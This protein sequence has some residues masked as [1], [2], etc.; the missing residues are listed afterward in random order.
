[1]SAILEWNHAVTSVLYLPV[2]SSVIHPNCYMV[3]SLNLRKHGDF[4]T[5]DGDELCFKQCS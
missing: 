2:E 5:T 4:E 1:M 3:S